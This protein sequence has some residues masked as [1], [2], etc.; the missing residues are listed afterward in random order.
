MSYDNGWSRS[1]VFSREDSVVMVLGQT[2]ADVES[3]HVA[4]LNYSL[5]VAQW[6]FGIGELYSLME[7]SKDY[8]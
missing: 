4:R 1:V 6:N 5:M 8:S 3:G 2:T 7:V